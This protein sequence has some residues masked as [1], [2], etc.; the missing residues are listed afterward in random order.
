MYL[1]LQGCL[2]SF[3]YLCGIGFVFV[4]T[5]I[6]T[7]NTVHLYFKPVNEMRKNIRKKVIL[8]YITFNLL[9]WSL[10]NALAHFS[11]RSLSFVGWDSLGT[12]WKLSLPLPNWFD[13][14]LSY[15]FQLLVF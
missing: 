11:V 1:L 6:E 9:L 3:H 2:N 8:L 4:L 12:D 5:A 13:F 10:V 15:T 14:N 7:M